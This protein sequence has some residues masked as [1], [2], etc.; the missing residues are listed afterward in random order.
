MDDQQPTTNTAESF[1]E[2]TELI[3]NYM[4]RLQQLK[5]EMSK[6]KDM[7]NSVY[8]NDSTYQVHEDAVKQANK[9]KAQTKKQIQ[10]QPNVAELESKIKDLKARLK[11]Y[12]DSLS[13]YLKMYREQTG[14]TQFE[15]ANGETFEIVYVAKAVKK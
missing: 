3:N 12:S 7:L 9:V 4:A 1:V 5:D 2:T 11:E 14:S 10:R 8:E 6:M 13:E 15:N